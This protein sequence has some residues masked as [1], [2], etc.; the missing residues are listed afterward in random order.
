MTLS[1]RSFLT[2]RA[3]AL[4]VSVTTGRGGKELCLLYSQALERAGRAKRHRRL[5]ASARAYAGTAVI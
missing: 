5:S 2:S 1:A 4:G 3:P